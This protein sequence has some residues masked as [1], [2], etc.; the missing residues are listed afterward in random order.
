MILRSLSEKRTDRALLLYRRMTP[1]RTK[2]SEDK[3]EHLL[4]LLFDGTVTS[5]LM[6]YSLVFYD[7]LMLMRNSS[8]NHMTIEMLQA[9]DR[10]QPSQDKL[11]HFENVRKVFLHGPIIHGVERPDESR[12]I[13]RDRYPVS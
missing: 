11:R 12:D 10:C 9:L 13:S 1:L 5:G 2:I 7:N 8:P 4:R 6:E 3:R